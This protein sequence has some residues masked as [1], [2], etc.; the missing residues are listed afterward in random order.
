MKDAGGD[1]WRVG[2]SSGLYR[3]TPIVVT[4]GKT[5]RFHAGVPFVAELEL[6]NL[7]KN[8]YILV[9][10]IRDQEG[11]RYYFDSFRKVGESK[12]KP[13]QPGVRSVDQKGREVVQGGFEKNRR[14]VWQVPDTLK[15]E[16]TA[17]PEI[18]VGPFPIKMVPKAIIIK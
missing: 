3:K 14:F 8:K 6:F 2:L 17:I 12:I 16:F 4:A 15:G 11:E 13:E 5:T 1:L 7:E 18:H 9:L 10:N